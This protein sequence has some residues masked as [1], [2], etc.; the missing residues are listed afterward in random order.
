MN[1][2]NLDQISAE[3]TQLMVDTLKN[4]AALQPLVKQIWR[5]FDI[6]KE[7]R[8]PIT[9]EGA[10]N[11]TEWTKLAGKPK[12]RYCQYLV[13]DG[14]RKQRDTHAV[15]VPV[16]KAG[17]VF[18]VDGVTY[19]IP[20]DIIKA[21]DG[22]IAWQRPIIPIAKDGYCRLEFNG[23]KIMKTDATP[24]PAPPKPTIKKQPKKKEAKKPL[25]HAKHPSAYA[26]TWCGVTSTNTNTARSK[27]H[28]TCPYCLAAIAA[29]VL[30]KN[31]KNQRDSIN[32]E[33]K[34]VR[35]RLTRH[36]TT[37]A[38]GRTDTPAYGYAVDSVEEE[39]TQV[40]KL[41]AELN[42]VKAITTPEQAVEAAKARIAER[43]VRRVEYE[44]QP[45]H[46]Q[47]PVAGKNRVE[48]TLCGDVIDIGTDAYEGTRM[49]YGVHAVATCGKCIELSKQVG[50]GVTQP[51][52]SATP[53]AITADEEHR[54]YMKRYKAAKRGAKFFTGLFDE[55]SEGVNSDYAALRKLYPDNTDDHRFPW[56]LPVKGYCLPAT[57]KEFMAQWEKAIGDFGATLQEGVNRGWMQ[58]EGFTPQVADVLTDSTP[59]PET[60]EVV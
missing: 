53:Q 20:E 2:T 3:I 37:I 49:A 17:S 25:R 54:E 42:A 40:A 7:T 41:Q 52:K 21:S 6:A 29:G 60:E 22:T 16:L 32:K 51:E 24:K 35:E 11:K 55:Y 9:I 30:V 56:T 4:E 33:L 28:A 12:M 14:S 5:A 44:K 50:L 1:T 13:K 48:M 23:L 46:I 57:K 26:S 39:R 58:C 34:Q 8:T 19:Q 59:E 36:E 31:P 47:S 43:E 38:A 45:V 27:N 10:K 15:R 18:K